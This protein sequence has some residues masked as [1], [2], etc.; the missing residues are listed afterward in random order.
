MTRR[1]ILITGATSGIGK[2]TAIFFAQ[3]GETV[4][5]CGSSE[6]VVQTQ[7][8]LQSLYPE[9]RIEGYRFDLRDSQQIQSALEEI[10][11]RFPIIE[12]LVNNAGI[13]RG[14]TIESISLAE[15]NEMFALNVTSFFLLC[16]SIVPSMKAQKY[17][18][19]INVS[20]I[21]GR[22]KSKLAGI[23]YTTTKAAIIGFTRQLAQEL[24][25]EG[26][27]VNAV[28]PSQTRTPMLEAFLNDE[29]EKKLQ[30]SIPLGY[31]AQPED[32]AKVIGFLASSDSDYMTGAILDVNGG[33]Y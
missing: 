1:T 7:Q 25:K 29:V 15:W 9:A 5:L 19:I 31:I 22:S 24:S 4:L 27:R 14:G 2:A 11:I 23:H 3:K 16:Q 12:V 33:Q 26:I 6:K 20:S 13:S 32:I 21:A 18:K 30:E 28:C 17:G 10:K 8:E